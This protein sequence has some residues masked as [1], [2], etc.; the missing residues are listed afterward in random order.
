MKL[1]T[2]QRMKYCSYKI[3]NLKYLFLTFTYLFLMFSVN[4]TAQSFVYTPKNPAF[5]GNSFNYQ[6]LQSSAQA[7]DTYKAPK[8]GTDKYGQSSDP[9]KDFSESLNRQILSRLTREIITRQF[10]E[11]GL[12]EGTYILGDYHINIGQDADGISINIVDNTTGS[13]TNVSV[14]YF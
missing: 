6:W 13:T 12:E 4:S 2:K 5:G 8:T 7:Q 10:G 1:K 14:P 11:E 3:N 9:V